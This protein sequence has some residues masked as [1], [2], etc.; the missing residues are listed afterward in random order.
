MF[1]SGNCK[2]IE[3]VSGLIEMC[4]NRVAFVSTFAFY[5]RTVTSHAV[6][7]CFTCFTNI[8]DVTDGAF[9]EV[10]HVA[11]GTSDGL[12]YLER[13]F[14]DVASESIGFFH[15]IAVFAPFRVA[16]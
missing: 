15:V 8:L 1:Y 11:G 14:G 10:N 16:S 6:L 9:D 7:Q 13:L 12:F 3:S 2:V 5:I 4:C